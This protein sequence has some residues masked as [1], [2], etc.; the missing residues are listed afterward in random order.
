MGVCE[1]VHFL[2]KFEKFQKKKIEKMKNFNVQFYFLKKK[3]GH[4]LNFEKS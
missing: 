2:R 4:F 1:N 3:I